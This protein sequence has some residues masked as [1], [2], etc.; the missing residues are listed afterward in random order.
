[1]ILPVAVGVA[2]P[3]SARRAMATMSGPTMWLDP[4]GPLRTNW[5]SGLAGGDRVWG[6]MRWN[7]VQALLTDDQS[8]LASRCASTWARQELAWGLSAPESF[9]TPITGITGQGYVWTA[10]R[11]VRS[12]TIGL[13]GLRPMANGL[14]VEPRLPDS[15]PRMALSNLSYRGRSLAIEVV[16]GTA[17]SR[18][19]NG[20]PLSGTLVPATRLHDGN[21]T[22]QIVLPKLP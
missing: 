13:F 1:M 19:L 4:Y 16:R 15:W 18:Q 12:L 14:I 11:A 8:D 22:L 3:E 9:P 10:G 20:Q 17:P 7:Y 6:F 21:N 2:S 5:N